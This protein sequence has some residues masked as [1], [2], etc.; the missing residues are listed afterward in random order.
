MHHAQPESASVVSRATFGKMETI[1]RM[2]LIH[3]AETRFRVRSWLRGGAPDDELVY[4]RIYFEN[5]LPL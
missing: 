5:S 1:D 4:L 2:R 3:R